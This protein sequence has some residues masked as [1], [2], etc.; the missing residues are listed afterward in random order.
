VDRYSFSVWLFHPQHLAGFNG[1]LQA[2]QKDLRVNPIRAPGIYTS[3][4]AAASGSRDRD[5]KALCKSSCP[6]YSF[7][8]DETYV[9]KQRKKI[10]EWDKLMQQLFIRRK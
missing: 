9:S 10:A 8:V 5:V 2:A 6:L 4:G 3:G 7:Y 1:A